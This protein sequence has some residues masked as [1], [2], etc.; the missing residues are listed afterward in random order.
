MPEEALARLEAERQKIDAK[1]AD[2]RRV[3]KKC[4]PATHSSRS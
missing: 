4:R 2:V 1:I 3:L